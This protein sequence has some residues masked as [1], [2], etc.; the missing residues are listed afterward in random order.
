MIL[1]LHVSIEGDHAQKPTVE[2]ESAPVALS[3]R[4][5]SPELQ[6]QRQ[7]VGQVS[8]KYRS[9]CTLVPFIG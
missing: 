8:P 4:Q 9:I 6:I 5:V 7:Q 2:S 3:S 1:E